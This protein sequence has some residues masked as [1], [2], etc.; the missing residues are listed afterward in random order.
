[1]RHRFNTF[2]FQIVLDL[3]HSQLIDCGCTGNSLSFSLISS[4]LKF[5][6]QLLG[7]TEKL[8]IRQWG[9]A[10]GEAE[11]NTGALYAYAS[12]ASIEHQ[13]TV[14]GYMPSHHPHH[15]ANSVHHTD[16]TTSV[17]LPRAQ[18]HPLF[19]VGVYAAIGFATATAS[20]LSTIVQYT[21]ALRASRL[22]FKRLL[23]GVVR[24]TMRWHVSEFRV[25]HQRQSSNR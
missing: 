21:G 23:V 17:D 18:D 7:L 6:L 24:A 4:R 2:I 19:Y 1:M 9:Q 8:W 13:I 22:L 20:I 16:F 12:S 14:H 11:N 25:N 5:I 10:Y 3:G 15:F